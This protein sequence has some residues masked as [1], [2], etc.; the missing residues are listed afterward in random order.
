MREPQEGIHKEKK[1]FKFMKRV[2]LIF[3]CKLFFKAN[4]SLAYSADH[5][6]IHYQ[7]P[8]YII[9]IYY[10]IPNLNEK[11]QAQIRYHQTNLK[12]ISKVYIK[13]ISGAEFYFNEKN[14]IFFPKTKKKP[15]PW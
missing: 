7:K 15:S 12:E 1:S 14:N 9:Y 10:T 6:R 8:F 5:L 3:I 11:R 4:V 2:L 13:L